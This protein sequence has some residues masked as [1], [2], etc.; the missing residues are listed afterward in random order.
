M[1]LWKSISENN[2]ITD[3]DIDYYLHNARRRIQHYI[4]TDIDELEDDDNVRDLYD[5]RYT[6]LPW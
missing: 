2:I 6:F 5:Q 3:Y 1:T 4:I